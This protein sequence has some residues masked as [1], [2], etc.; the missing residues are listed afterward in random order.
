M[1]IGHRLTRLGMDLRAVYDVL[2]SPSI[3]SL[4]EQRRLA[5][6]VK[7]VAT[8]LDQA[9][10]DLESV[11]E[12]ADTGVISMPGEESGTFPGVKR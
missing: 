3:L 1:T 8:E 7:R 11:P 4:A 5:A 9:R 10:I 6:D 12:A 2:R